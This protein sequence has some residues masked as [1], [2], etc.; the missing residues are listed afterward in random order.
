LRKIEGKI[1]I[2]L[3]LH[4]V[5]QTTTATTATKITMECVFAEFKELHFLDAG[6]RNRLTNTQNFSVANGDY[7]VCMFANFC[8]RCGEICI[9]NSMANIP[10]W[11]V[12]P[13]VKCKCRVRYP[14]NR[15]DYI[16]HRL[17]EI[18]RMKV[19]ALDEML[20]NIRR[21][22]MVTLVN[23]VLF[24]VLNKNITWE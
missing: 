16:R 17:S 2:G 9:S 12:T 4:Q 6:E 10:P 14:R 20:D 18:H 3:L 8:A 1:K 19:Q 23:R 13:N 21:R 15:P 24:G 11:E 22:D 5:V 7:S